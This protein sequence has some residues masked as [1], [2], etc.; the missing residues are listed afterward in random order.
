MTVQE[1]RKLQLQ[2]VAEA[3][4]LHETLSLDELQ[5]AAQGTLTKPVLKP[6]ASVS[7]PAAPAPPPIQTGQA[8]DSSPVEGGSSQPVNA[9]TT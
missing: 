2:R 3:L 1:G 5:Q 6:E 8:S 4:L 7:E 9:D